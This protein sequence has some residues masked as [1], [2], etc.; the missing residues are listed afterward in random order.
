MATELAEMIDDMFFMQDS[1]N[2]KGEFARSIY[3][4]YKADYNIEDDDDYLHLLY[5]SDNGIYEYEYQHEADNCAY[6]KTLDYLK[7]Y[8][9]SNILQKLY[10][11]VI[12]E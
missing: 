8:K 1:I 2:E 3:R 12:I 9:K 10:K 11:R 6:E 4:R 5:E 7:K